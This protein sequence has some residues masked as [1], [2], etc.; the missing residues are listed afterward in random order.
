[1]IRTLNEHRRI[2]ANR[3]KQGITHPLLEDHKRQ[4]RLR[5]DERYLL[6]PTIIKEDW[7]IDD[8][9]STVQEVRQNTSSGREMLI[10]TVYYNGTLEEQSI[11]YR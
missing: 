8:V 7:T 5:F 4:V 11:E 2:F 6:P 1:M 10:T 9:K 3:F